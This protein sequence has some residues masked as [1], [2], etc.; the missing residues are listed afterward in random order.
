MAEK[1]LAKNYTSHIIPVIADAH[2]KALE[3]RFIW[4]KAAGLY[5]F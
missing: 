4:V 3:S 5:D 2:A 1:E